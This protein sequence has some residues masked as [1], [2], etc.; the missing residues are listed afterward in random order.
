[1]LSLYCAGIS[2]QKK[3]KCKS[4][5]APQVESNHCAFWSPTDLKSALLTRRDQLR[6]TVGPVG[7]WLNFLFGMNQYEERKIQLALIPITV[8]DTNGFETVWQHRVRPQYE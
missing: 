1:V 6:I 4:N 3:E 7:H 5:G 2:Q 8:T